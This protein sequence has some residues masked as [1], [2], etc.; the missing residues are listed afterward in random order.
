MAGE[1]NISVTSKSIHLTFFKVESWQSR[2][3]V[4]FQSSGS[5]EATEQTE[6]QKQG[7]CWATGSSC[8]GTEEMWRGK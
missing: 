8:E 1:Q 6:E 3:N 7:K 2:G 5:A 4:R